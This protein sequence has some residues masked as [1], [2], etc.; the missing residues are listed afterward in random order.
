M[1]RIS[2]RLKL[3]LTFLAV[4]LIPFGIMAVVALYHSS[5]TIEQ[6][7]YDKLTAVRE[8]K[9]TQIEEYFETVRKQISTFSDDPSV[10]EAMKGFSR[11]FKS[12]T[13]QLD[14]SD[15]LERRS[16]VRDYYLSQF[17]PEY[18]S[19]TGETVEIQLESTL[20]SLSPTTLALQSRYIAEKSHPLDS[21]D[22][23]SRRND[24]TEYDALHR[25]F[26]PYLQQFLNEFG[27]HDIFLIESKGGHI[28][29]SVSKELDFATSLISGPYAETHFGRIFQEANDAANDDFT[30]LADFEPYFPSYGSIASFIAAPI[31]RNDERIGVV[32]F[33]MPVDHIN[34]IMTSDGKWADVGLG[35]SGETYL[36]G[37]DHLLR[38]NSRFLL[39]DKAGYL[40]ALRANGTGKD[41]LNLISSKDSSILLQS[42]NSETSNKALAGQ[43][44]V[45]IVSDYRGIDVLSSYSPVDISNVS[46]AI[47]AEMD[48]AEAFEPL[49]DLLFQV[50]VW[51]LIGTVLILSTAWYMA[52]GVSGS[53]VEIISSLK[54]S[55]LQLD[56]A[57]KQVAGSA[58][59]LAQGATEQAA[60]LQETAASLEEISSMAAHNADNSRQADTISGVLKSDAQTGVSTVSDMSS[61]IQAIKTAA[62][63]TSLIVKTIDDIAFQ[64]NL[65]ALNAAVEAA[66]AGEA[67]KGFAVVAEEVR[68]LAQRSSEA[69]KDTA[70]KIRR[71]TELANEGVKVTEEVGTSLQSIFDNS[72]KTSS[73]ISEISAASKE[74]S[75]G[76]G[77]V[78]TAISQLDQVTQTNASVAEEAAAAG[79]ELFAQTKTVSRGVEGLTQLV[80]G[81]ATVQLDTKPRNKRSKKKEAQQEKRKNPI[82]QIR[83]IIPEHEE[84]EFSSASAPQA[85]KALTAEQIIPLDNDDFQG[86]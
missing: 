69:A 24:L 25:R 67:G 85:G 23:L 16:R 55:S 18:E 6:A 50:L 46:W 4:G 45:S 70:D 43:S 53:I 72:S 1:K 32:V 76:L 52:R 61:A 81:G 34:S 20:S 38:T 30:R 77:Q 48:E 80:F 15:E 7:S 19:Q 78:N 13:E 63:E 3:M 40:E 42:V 12:Y 56:G 64:T 35:A 79:E 86:F 21:K 41:Q 83:Q 11:A 82:T 39:E 68:K 28:V 8:F 44:G 51:C 58:Q 59:S 71:S 22:Q 36:L 31:F 5:S 62:D 29:Y 75:T 2:L 9:R 54:D 84:D 33:R 14:D 49:Y 65:L 10:Q 27:F 57:A 17:G 60:S 66:R 74:Q 47:L 73:L 26:H 37:S